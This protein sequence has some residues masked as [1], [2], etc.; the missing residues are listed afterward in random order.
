PK[1]KKRKWIG[2]VKSDPVPKFDVPSH[3]MLVKAKDGGSEP[4][5]NRIVEI[6]E[7]LEL[8]ELRD[9]NSGFVAYVPKGAIARGRKLVQ[10]GNGAFPCAS[11]HGA[12]LKGDG[13]VP[14]LAGR[15]PSGLVRQL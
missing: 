12:N 6:P 3:N 2:G 15:S 5:G 10:S 4:I 14:A 1:L 7:S 8:V 11:C 9:P 13:N